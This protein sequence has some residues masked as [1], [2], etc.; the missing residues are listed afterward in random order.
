MVSLKKYH[1]KEIDNSIYIHSIDFGNFFYK[2]QIDIPI[3]KPKK[4]KKG[5][6]SPMPS[7]VVDVFVKKGDKIKK[8]NHLLCSVP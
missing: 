1:I 4:K 2:L 3:L 5:Y 8:T 6:V 7:L